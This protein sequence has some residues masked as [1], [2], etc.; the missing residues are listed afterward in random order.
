[1]L[2]GSDDHMEKCSIFAHGFS[3]HVFEES[4]FYPT[5]DLIG[6]LAIGFGNIVFETGLNM[7]LLI[8]VARLPILLFVPLKRFRKWGCL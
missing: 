3:V 4:I 6:I 8:M 2:I 5:L 7:L 1:M